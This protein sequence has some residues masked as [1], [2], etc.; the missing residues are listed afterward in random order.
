MGGLVSVLRNCRLVTIVLLLA[1]C[2]SVTPYRTQTA[3][4]PC[5]VPSVDN[6]P[7]ECQASAW[8]RVANDYDVLFVEFDDMGLAYPKGGANVGDAWNQIERSVPGVG[9]DVQEWRDQPGRVRAWMEA[10]RARA[11]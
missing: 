5:E 6:E 9:R 8:E 10:Q 4:K 11:G 3:G 2:T 7:R 1:G